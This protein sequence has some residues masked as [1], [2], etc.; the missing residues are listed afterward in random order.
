MR[1]L[2]IWE[3]WYFVFFGGEGGG[4]LFMPGTV[5]HLFCVSVTWVT[6]GSSDGL[7]VGLSTGCLCL[8]GCLSGLI[9]PF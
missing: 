7:F 2:G 5:L 9:V 1:W 6:W 3:S 8:D 4:I